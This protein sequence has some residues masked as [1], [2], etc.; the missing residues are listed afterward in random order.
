[1]LLEL[2][3]GDETDSIVI[4]QNLRCLYYD[5]MLMAQELIDVTRVDERDEHRVSR[6][7]YVHIKYSNFRIQDDQHTGLRLLVVLYFNE[8]S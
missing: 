2:P 6:R 7:Y 4:V 8:Q 3:V 1:M 5:I